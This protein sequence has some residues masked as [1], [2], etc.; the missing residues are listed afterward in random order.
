MEIPIL[1]NVNLVDFNAEFVILLLFVLLAMEHWF[2]I[3]ENANV[4]LDIYY[5]QDF[6]ILIQIH[7][8]IKT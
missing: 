5:L 3:M 8:K 4:L 7:V 6:V 2:L 1:V